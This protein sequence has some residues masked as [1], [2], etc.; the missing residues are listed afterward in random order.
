MQMAQLTGLSDHFPLL[1]S[2]DEENW[3]PRSLRMLKCWQDIPGY[4]QFVV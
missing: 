4:K 2:V 1:L 3:G